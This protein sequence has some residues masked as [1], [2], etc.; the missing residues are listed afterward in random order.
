[1]HTALGLEAATM[2]SMNQS[3]PEKIR[4][5]VAYLDMV[6]HSAEQALETEVGVDLVLRGR[7]I[8]AQVPSTPTDPV[9]GLCTVT[10]G[11]EEP[12]SSLIEPNEFGRSNELVRVTGTNASRDKK[13]GVGDKSCQNLFI[14]SYIFC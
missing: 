9:S 14:E 1:M 13:V 11:E 6:V 12:P 10:A 2:G 3:D 4:T 7:S 5:Q 8:S